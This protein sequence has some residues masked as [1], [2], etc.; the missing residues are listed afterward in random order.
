MMIDDA[1]EQGTI[2]GAD[3]GASSV[4]IGVTLDPRSLRCHIGPT[5][6]SDRADHHEPQ[7]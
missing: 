5:Y 7:R 4:F 6:Y 3:S 1:D 2:M